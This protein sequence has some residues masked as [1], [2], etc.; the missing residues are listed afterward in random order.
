MARI[1]TIVW[2]V[3]DTGRATRF[4]TQALGYVRRDEESDVLIPAGGAPGPGLVMEPSDRTHL[5]LY[6][7]S[8]AEQ[9]AEVERLVSLGAARADWTYPDDAD[10]IVLADTEGNLFC[11][12]NKGDD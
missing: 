4:W 5:D 10:F 12:V 6:T 11:V 1:G 3:R 7:D 2:H 9:L 8:R